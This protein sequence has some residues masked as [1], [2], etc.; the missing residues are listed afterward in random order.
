MPYSC[1]GDMRRAAGWVPHTPLWTA[2][3]TRGLST[4]M[5]TLWMRPR[6]SCAG[7]ETG[8]SL[9]PSPAVGDSVVYVGSQGH[10]VYALYAS[11]R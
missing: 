11:D 2:W 10:Y 4:A 6:G 9:T 7:Y 8:Y 3:C 5:A 1:S